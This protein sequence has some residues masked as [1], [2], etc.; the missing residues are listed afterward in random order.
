[1]RGNSPS[2]QVAYRRREFMSQDESNDDDD[3]DDDV[4]IEVHRKSA[5][6]AVRG[7]V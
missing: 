4:E 5:H 2:D 1:M 7:Q 3:A 6:Y